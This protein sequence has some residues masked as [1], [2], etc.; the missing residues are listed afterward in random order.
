M[1]EEEMDQVAVFPNTAV[2]RMVF[3]GHHHG[4]DGIEVG[5]AFELPIEKN[6]L[7]DPKSQPIKGAEYVDNLAKFLQ[8]KIYMVNCAHAVTSYFGFVQD[9]I[10]YK[11]DQQ[12]HRFLKM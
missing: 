7:E 4:K 9:T 6:K 3:D 8:R 2:D 5:D 1:T 10:Q 12:I 11:K